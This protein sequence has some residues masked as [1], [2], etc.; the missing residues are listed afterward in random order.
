MLW[1][2]SRRRAWRISLVGTALLAAAL[3]T[4]YIGYFR[5]EVW[6]ADRAADQ[7]QVYGEFTEAIRR[8][9][10]L[11]TAGTGLFEFL[12]RSDAA[13]YRGWTMAVADSDGFQ[14]E[15]VFAPMVYVFVPR[16]LWPEKPAVRQGWEFSGLV[17]GP[18]YIAW[19]DS[20]LSAGLYPALYLGAGWP[21]V[22]LGAV[23]LG[24]LMACLGWLA[25][26]LGGPVLA[27]LYTL[28]LLPYA[29]RL[30]EAWTVGAF[31]GPIINFVYV[32]LIFVAARTFSGLLRVGRVGG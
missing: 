17:F 24:L 31:S 4:A 5:A 25:S 12:A 10:L 13:P 9:G 1:T 8:D 18:E 2:H 26:R 16:I 3:V 11:P 20:S 14:P 29:L 30:D 7:S 32:T 27:G 6:Y 15:L 22:M 23:G 21:A 28:S 19:S